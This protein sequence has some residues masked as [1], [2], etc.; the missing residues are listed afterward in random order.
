MKTEDI[1]HRTLGDLLSIDVKVLNKE[2]GRLNN[3]RIVQAGLHA[4]TVYR[5]TK[6]TVKNYSWNDI[7]E[8]KR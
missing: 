7:E 8:V 6:G 5:N 3:G 4:A 1:I 2:T